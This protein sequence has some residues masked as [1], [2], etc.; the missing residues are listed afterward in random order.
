M[1]PTAAVYPVKTS[2][3]IEEAKFSPCLLKRTS[4]DD[5]PQNQ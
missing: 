3:I 1:W 2:N 5:Q 4:I